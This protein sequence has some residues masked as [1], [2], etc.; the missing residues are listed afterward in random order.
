ML[1]PRTT[2]R[3]SGPYELHDCCPATFQRSMVKE[4]L[5]GAPPRT[6]LGNQCQHTILDAPTMEPV[7]EL[8]AEQAV[9]HVGAVDRRGQPAH[10]DRPD[11]QAV[12]TDGGAAYP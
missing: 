12:E 9:R 2:G 5:A 8:H 3:T 11:G 10:L 6:K 1:A 7:E 4:V